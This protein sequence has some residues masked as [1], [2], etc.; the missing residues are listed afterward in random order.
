M[1][2]SIR[3]NRNPW[4]LGFAAA[5]LATAG[6]AAAQGNILAS[7]LVPGVSSQG[8]R[9]LAFDGAA[10]YAV[11]DNRGLYQVRLT[12]FT[13]D[14]KTSAASVVGS[15]NCPPS[16]NWAMDL[17]WR[18]GRLY[19]AADLES[20]QKRAK[21][22]ALDAGTGEFRNKFDSPFDPGVHVNGLTWDGSY[23]YASSYDSRHV[24]RM[25]HDGAVV[26]SFRA[27]HAVNHGLAFDGR[28]L[29]LVS[30]RP[31]FDAR[32]YSA[33][34]ARLASFTFDVNDEYVGGACQGRDR[35]GVRSLFVST[36]TGGRFIYEIATNS[37]IHGGVTVEPASLGRVKA[38]F[39]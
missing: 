3:R 36:F 10:T 38:L 28:S 6:T 13:Y 24:Y 29:W 39:R 34:G 33:S 12:K 22:Y 32:A 35:D 5:L 23:L 19:L 25:T 2:S 17:A 9:G 31:H 11:A 1:R 20:A 16:V 14:G 21:I 26:G 27:D 15:F 4:R 18:P 37:D 7:F 8:P 30:G